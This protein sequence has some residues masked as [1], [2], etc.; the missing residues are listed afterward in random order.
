MPRPGMHDGRVFT[1]YQSNCELNSNIQNKN[2]YSN[3][4]DYKEYIQ[5][6]SQSIRDMFTTNKVPDSIQGCLKI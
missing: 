3:N 1:V 4:V 5:K 2:G 6:N